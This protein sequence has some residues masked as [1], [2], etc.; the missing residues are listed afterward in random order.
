MQW[1]LTKSPLFLNTDPAS[2]GL[3]DPASWNSPIK[4]LSVMASY[5]A[6]IQVI[7]VIMDLMLQKI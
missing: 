3:L 6:A 7:M 4:G 1:F 2:L 5:S